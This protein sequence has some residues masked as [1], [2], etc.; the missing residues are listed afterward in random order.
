MK[1]YLKDYLAGR[2]REEISARTR[3]E[4]VPEVPKADLGEVVPPSV[5]F[6]TCQGVGYPENLETQPSATQA[7]DPE[8]NW[9]IEAM[10][11]Q[12]PGAGPIPFLVAREGFDSRGGCC[13]SC[14][15]PLNRD[16]AYRCASC[17]RAANL[18]LELSLSRRQEAKGAGL[19]S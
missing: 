8:V 1:D 5:T 2:K 9:R 7:N 6:D 14:G 19:P 16:D 13:L 15:D 4:G 18:A 17:S 11:P 12:I 3:G 10:L